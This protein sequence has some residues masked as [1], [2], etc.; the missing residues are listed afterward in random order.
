MRLIADMRE[1]GCPQTIN[2]NGTM[3]VSYHVDRTSATV[4]PFPLHY[5]EL[6]MTDRCLVG[7]CIRADSRN[8]P[9]FNATIQCALTVAF[10]LLPCFCLKA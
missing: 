7:R 1:G 6:V 10:S 3:A 5:C 2:N 8:A 4:L 9:P